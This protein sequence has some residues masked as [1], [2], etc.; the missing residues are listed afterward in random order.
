M[1][2]ATQAV[3]P[4]AETPNE[5]QSESTLSRVLKHMAVRLVLISM[6]VVM[7]VCLTI[8][9]ANMGGYVDEIRRGAIREQVGLEVQG[10]PAFRAMT[11]E[12]RTELIEDMIRVREEQMGLNRPFIL[13]SSGFLWDALTLNLGRAESM[14]S[15][16]GSAQVRLIL[17]ERLRQLW[18]CGVFQ[19]LFSSS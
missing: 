10:D 19:T 4:A 18:S 11:Q 16:S 3:Q 2:E 8:L 9:I 14:T 1:T 15:D 5:K 12:Q 13:R 17:L 6:T 7:G